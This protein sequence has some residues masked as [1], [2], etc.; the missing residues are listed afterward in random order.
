MYK[1]VSLREEETKQKEED[2]HLSTIR[3]RLIVT[4]SPLQSNCP[5]KIS[6]HGIRAHICAC[7]CVSVR[8]CTYLYASVR[9]CAPRRTFEYEARRRG[10]ADKTVAELGRLAAQGQP[11]V[12]LVD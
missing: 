3:Y 12:D 11:G 6:A 10:C 1:E 9:I 2:G 7:L 8:I 4:D 5:L